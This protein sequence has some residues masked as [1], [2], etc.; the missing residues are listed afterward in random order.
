MLSISSSPFWSFHSYVVV[1]QKTLKEFRKSWNALL[2]AADINEFR[3]HDLRHTAASYLAMSGCSTIEIAGIL[4]HKSLEMSKRY[5]HLN[6]DHNT[7]LIKRMTKRMGIPD[8]R[9]K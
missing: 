8:D 1:G 5:T 3:F 7:V 2:K 6:Q 9:D 4:G